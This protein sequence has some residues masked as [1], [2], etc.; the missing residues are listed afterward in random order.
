MKALYPKN[1]YLVTYA[2]LLTDKVL[3]FNGILNHLSLEMHDKVLDFINET[4]NPSMNSKDSY[5][6]HRV[7]SLDDAW[8]TQ[9]NPIIVES[10]QTELRDSILEKYLL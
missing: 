8:K 1:F 3:G 10:I 5:S 9:L 6:I 2:D 4:K 7:K